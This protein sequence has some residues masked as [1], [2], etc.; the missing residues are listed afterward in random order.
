[1]AATAAGLS[2]SLANLTNPSIE[3][4]RVLHARETKRKQER[5]SLMGNLR[6]AENLGRATRNFCA[7]DTGGDVA[8]GG[9]DEQAAHGS[10]IHVAR[11][12]CTAFAAEVEQKA[13][14]IG[15]SDNG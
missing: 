5:E 8:A 1:M 14:N 11:A 6:A 9:G 2:E 3:R 15:R 10:Q 12:R 4:G 7:R 13:L